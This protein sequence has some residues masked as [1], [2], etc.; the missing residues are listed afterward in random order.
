ME[1][2][3]IGEVARRAGLTTRT[4]RH[5]DDLGLLR[6]S[7]RTSGD[8]RLY[9]PDDLTR[10]LRIQQLKSLGLGLEEI[11]FALDDP[12][13][14]PAQVL[15]QQE[16][17]IRER[18]A[19]ER[20]LLARLRRLQTVPAASWEDLLE[21]IA[22]TEQLRHPDAAVR[23]RAALNPERPAPLAELLQV[24]RTERVPGVL[25]AA[26]WA[27]VRYGD[28]ALSPVV[29]LLDD[30]EPRVRTQAAHVLGK[31]GD[32]RAV[33]PLTGALGDEDAGVRDKA[34][35][36]LGRLGG[37]AALT[38]LAAALVGADEA[39][40]PGLVVALGS[41]GGVSED[42]VQEALAAVLRADS[43]LTREDGAEVLG[44]RGAAA[45]IEPLRTLMADP[46]EDVQLSALMALDAIGTPEASEV[47][48]SVVGRPGRV[49]ALATRLTH[50]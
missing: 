38:A 32:A 22:L 44:L 10:L 3:A 5:Y 21:T 4:L 7:G 36:A 8:Y 25:E 6:P 41:V 35:H 47:I 19:V 43:P 26:T 50:R 12:D 24:L 14:D 1:W 28:A 15:A 37:P 46:D 18:I 17:A 45:A 48:G 30:R 13:F 42:A 31:L 11:G 40:R 9:S 23:F 34:A 27:I 33:G 16:A 29:E 39:L 49:G 2:L 20:Q